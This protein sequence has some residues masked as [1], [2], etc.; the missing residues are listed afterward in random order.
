[1]KCIRVSLLSGSPYARCDLKLAAQ[2][3]SSCSATLLYV[4]SSDFHQ[5]HKFGAP[6]AR[7]ERKRVSI[8][9]HTVVKCSSALCWASASR[10]SMPLLL[11][12]IALRTHKVY[13]LKTFELIM[14]YYFMD[15]PGTDTA[16]VTCIWQHGSQQDKARLT[17]TGRELMSHRIC[18]SAE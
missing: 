4:P 7:A 10:T 14:G 5:L 9:L 13:K 1:M 3:M 18:H 2:P 6:E 8:S 17:F 11:Q 15:M 16:R 12:S